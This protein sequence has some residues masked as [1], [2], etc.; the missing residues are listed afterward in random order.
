[1][2]CRNLATALA[3]GSLVLFSTPTA[4]Q[5]HPNLAKGLSNPTAYEFGQ[6]D[7]VN[8]SNGS[9]SV[10]IP[11][12]IEYV[13]SSTLSYRFNLVYIHYP[14]QF[15]DNGQTALTEL[16]VRS[17]AGFGWMI[18]FGRLFAPDANNDFS[19]NRW[20]LLDGDGSKRIFWGDL[21]HSTNGSEGSASG[22]WTLYTRDGSFMRL[23]TN[24]PSSSCGSLTISCHVVE[25]A[26]GTRRYFETVEGRIRLIADRFGNE[27]SITYSG[28][29]A[30]PTQWT[31][32]DGIR[33]H[34][35]SLSTDPSGQSRI[36]QVNLAKFGGGTT[37]YTFSYINRDTY[38]PHDSTNGHTTYSFLEQLNLP[39]TERFEFDYVPTHRHRQTSSRM[40]FSNA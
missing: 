22:Q 40:G 9:L 35:V 15:E 1:M 38:K 37:P 7:S 10:A 8:L 6:L 18:E 24:Q 29:V 32:N 25:H 14:W 2:N 17:N 39:E 16:D 20:A 26:D 21:W 28:G 5:E 31:V 4:A 27:V 13:V 30:Q 11:L 23:R 3:I 33:T 12:G 34:T 36:N 19:G